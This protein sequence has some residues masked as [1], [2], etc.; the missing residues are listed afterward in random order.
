MSLDGF[1]Y[2][3]GFRI[4]GRVDGSVL[5]LGGCVQRVMVRRRLGKWRCEVRDEGNGKTELSEDEGDGEV[6]STGYSL[7]AKLKEETERPFA[8]FRE[9]IL[10]GAAASASVGAFISGLRIL[11]AL[12]GV[13]GVQPISETIPNVGIDVLVVAGCV[14]LLRLDARTRERRLQRLTRGA[15]LAALRIERFDGN[16]MVK[17]SSF[18]GEKRPI[19]V[20]GSAETVQ[21]VLNQAK[22]F[23]SD[24]ENADLVIIP[25]PTSGEF[26]F[27]LSGAWTAKPLLTNEWLEW[28][29]IEKRVGKAE[30]D[31]LFVTIVRKDG[32]VGARRTGRPSWPRLL[33]EVNRLPKKDKYGKP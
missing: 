14:A 22:R 13:S 21:E 5:G 3:G 8:R 30:G 33:D 26:K 12:Q 29:S 1:V 25:L 11:A 32:R 17:L 24:L 4:S 16:Q 9:F 7:R 19:I 18:R 15:R 2:C 10:F 23:A 28:L 27:E 31:E 6:P 20:A